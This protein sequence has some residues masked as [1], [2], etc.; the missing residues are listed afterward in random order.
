MFRTSSD[1]EFLMSGQFS[2]NVSPT[3]KADKFLGDS[4]DFFKDAIDS[5]TM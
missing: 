1:L 3:T 5:F 4:L 2:L